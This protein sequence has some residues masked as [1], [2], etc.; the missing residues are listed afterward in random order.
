MM[1]QYLMT[2][3]IHNQPQVCWQSR[4]NIF[5]NAIPLCGTC[6]TWNMT[7]NA[8]LLCQISREGPTA[9]LSW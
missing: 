9:G 1:I 3:A 6:S 2:H 5:L 4:C 7:L 8:S